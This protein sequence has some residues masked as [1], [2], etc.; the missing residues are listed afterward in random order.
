MTR[1]G[2]ALAANLGRRADGTGSVIRGQVGRAS[3]VAAGLAGGP[4]G[5]EPGLGS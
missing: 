5:P 2:Q 1:I 3:V 4:A